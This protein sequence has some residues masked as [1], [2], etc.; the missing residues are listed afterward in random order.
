MATQAFSLANNL[1]LNNSGITGNGVFTIWT[2]SN[3]SNNNNLYGMRLIVEY[4]N[5]LPT[6]VSVTAVVE[7][8]QSGMWFPVAYQFNSF[9]NMDNGPQRIL[10]LLPNISSD[11]AGIDDDMYV[12][13]SVIARISR[14]QGKAGATMRVRLIAQ[15]NSYGTGS[16][17]E[18][19]KVSMYGELFD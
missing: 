18:S 14:Q 13:N 1:V 19:I 10:L 3:I 6:S 9:N 15:E 8:L 4:S 5:P 12:G 17:F 7:A 2:S 16:Q 11:N